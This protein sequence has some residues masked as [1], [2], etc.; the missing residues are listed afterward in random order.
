MV[1]GNIM[2]RLVLGNRLAFSRQYLV[3]FNEYGWMVT[4]WQIVLAPG[5]SL[6]EAEH[7]SW[8]VLSWK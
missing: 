2:M 3:L 5:I 8:L 6:M 4:G 7:G 1:T